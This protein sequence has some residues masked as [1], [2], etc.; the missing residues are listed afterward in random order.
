[1]F[2]SPTNAPLDL[3]RYPKLPGRRDSRPC[4][5]L[6]GH[7][8]LHAMLP[9]GLRLQVLSPPCFFRGQNRPI[10]GYRFHCLPAA[11]ARVTHSPYRAAHRHLSPLL[12]C[13]TR[14]DAGVRPIPSATRTGP[15]ASALIGEEYEPLAQMLELCLTDF[16]R[17]P[18]KTRRSSARR[19]LGRR[20]Q[21]LGSDWR[22]IR[23]LCGNRGYRNSYRNSGSLKS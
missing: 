23:R 22:G 7:A 2:E 20:K 9:C 14:A 12:G 19:K 18:V 6:F 13:T 17:L 5:Y 3:A 10:R 1:M 21:S 16:L 8:D 15:K 11:Y 4:R